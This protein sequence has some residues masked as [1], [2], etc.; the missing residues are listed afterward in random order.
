MRRHWLPG[1]RVF[2]VGWRCFLPG[3]DSK[4]GV[5]LHPAVMYLAAG[6]HA[7]SFLGGLMA[8]RVGAGACALQASPAGAA[9]CRDATAGIHALVHEQQ[10]LHFRLTVVPLPANLESSP[11][12]TLLCRHGLGGG[13]G[14]PEPHG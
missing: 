2:G 10:P 9:H 12:S 13:T 5:S 14:H 6:A 11:A 3:V 7:V 8:A 4:V 1:N